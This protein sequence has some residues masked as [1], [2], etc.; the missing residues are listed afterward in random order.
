MSSLKFFS[1]CSAPCERFSF[2]LHFVLILLYIIDKISIYPSFTILPRCRV[3]QACSSSDNT[4]TAQWAA[5]GRSSMLTSA[6]GVLPPARSPG[7][8]WVQPVGCTR[9]YLYQLLILSQQCCLKVYLLFSNRF[10]LFCSSCGL[11]TLSCRNRESLIVEFLKI[12][13]NP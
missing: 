12:Y 8:W 1:S 5:C 11:C 7:L 4:L 9:R 10:I 2:L 13:I 3:G 6:L